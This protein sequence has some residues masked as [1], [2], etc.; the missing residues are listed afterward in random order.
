MSLYQIPGFHIDTSFGSGQGEVSVQ[1][2]YC[3]MNCEVLKTALET[4]HELFL[5]PLAVVRLTVQ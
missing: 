2:L 4:A 1:K 5:L 3:A